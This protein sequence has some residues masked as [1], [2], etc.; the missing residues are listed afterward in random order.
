MSGEKMAIDSARLYSVKEAAALVPSARGGH[1]CI[2][3]LHLWREQGILPMVGRKR[4]SRTYWFVRGSDLIKTLAKDGNSPPVGPV[5]ESPTERAEAIER[6][7][8]MA[9]AQGYMV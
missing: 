4:G 2:R 7:L 6:A 8:R 1:V 3:T 5:C 9:R